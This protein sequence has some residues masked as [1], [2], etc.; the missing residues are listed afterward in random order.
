MTK[1]DKWDDIRKYGL[2]LVIAVLYTFFVHTLIDAVLDNP[3]YE[4]FCPIELKSLGEEFNDTEYQNC[5]AKL[6]D[7][8][9]YFELRVFIISAVLG[10][11][12]IIIGLMLPYEKNILNEWIGSGLLFGGLFSLFVGT[13]RSFGQ[14][15]EVWR[16]IIM[17]FELILVIFLAYRLYGR[18]K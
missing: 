5:Q 1:V 17:L 15:G 6:D 14:I 9:Q 4:D 18:K 12:S 13:I 8:R 10:L 7:A 3:R 11:V 2:I 16:P